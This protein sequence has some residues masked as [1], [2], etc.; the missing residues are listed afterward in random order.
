MMIMPL[1]PQLPHPLRIAT[2]GSTLAL[3]QA[4]SVRQRLHTAGVASELLV[5]SSSRK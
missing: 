3:V 2:R 4:E 1:A 5:V